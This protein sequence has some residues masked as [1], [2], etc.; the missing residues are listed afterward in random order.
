MAVA[1]NV[2]VALQVVKDAGT[3]MFAG[4]ASIG[5]S[6]SVIVTVWAHVEVCI[7]ASVAVQTTVFVPTG[8]VVPNALLFV[9]TTPEQ[10]SVAV[11]APIATPVFAQ[12]PAV[13]FPTM[14]LG[15]VITGGGST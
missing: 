8:K 5:F 11:A 6:T 14:L 3:E 15:Q 7:L 2:A 13:L 10:L 12:S 4:Q 1:E 9:T